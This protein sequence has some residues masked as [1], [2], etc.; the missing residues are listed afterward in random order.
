[1]TKKKIL[2]PKGGLGPHM[3]LSLVHVVYI[4]I[5][6]TCCNIYIPKHTY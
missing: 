6:K 3:G 1:M 2:D 4:D 5:Y